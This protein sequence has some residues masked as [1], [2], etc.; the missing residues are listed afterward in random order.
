MFGELRMSISVLEVT[1]HGLV[2]GF[3][4]IRSTPEGQMPPYCYQ[5]DKDGYGLSE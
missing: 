1:F 4:T 3:S 2:S 5:N